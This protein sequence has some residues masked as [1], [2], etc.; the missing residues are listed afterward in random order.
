MFVDASS[1]WL[2]RSSVPRRRPAYDLRRRVEL[3]VRETKLAGRRLRGGARLRPSFFIVG[4]QKAGTTALF[5]H[6]ARH[7]DVAAPLAKE[8]HYFDVAAHRGA[9]WY[10]A[11]FPLIDGAA[12]GPHEPARLTFD[13]SPYYLFHPAVAERLRRYAPDARII[14]LLRDPAARAWSH[15]WHE[16]S[17]GY[18]QLEPMAAFEA[19]AERVPDPHDHV[20]PSLGERFAHQH[21]SYLARSEYDRQLERWRSVFPA[22]QILCLRSEDL[23]ADPAATLGQVAAFLNL[24]PF[25]PSSFRALN[26]GDY[27]NPPPDVRDW[28]NS[29]LAASQTSLIGMLGPHFQWSQATP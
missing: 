17:R 11:H 1:F 28:L 5:D 3:A 21:F 7:P 20:G 4:A 15:Y 25:D 26:T 18:E 9:G 24:S 10:E 16:W 29:R 22:E 2:R 6:L 27:D 12:A 13:A 8:V 23:F 19:E 14:A